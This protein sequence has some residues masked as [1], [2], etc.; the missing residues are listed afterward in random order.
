MHPHALQELARQ[1]TTDLIRE[2]DR[3]RLAA[4]ARAPRTDHGLERSLLRRVTR[5]LAV[6]R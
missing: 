2:A 1:R 3:H 6:V 5:R 4:R